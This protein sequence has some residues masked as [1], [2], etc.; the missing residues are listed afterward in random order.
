MKHIVIIFLLLY[1]S[2]LRSQVLPEWAHNYFG[3]DLLD[4][5]R[6]QSNR[7]STIDPDSICDKLIEIDRQ[8]GNNYINRF[9]NKAFSDRTKYNID[10]FTVY[11]NEWIASPSEQKYK[12]QYDMHLSFPILIENDD[13]VL[14][15]LYDNA[16]GPLPVEANYKNIL[17]NNIVTIAEADGSIGIWQFPEEYKGELARAFLYAAIVYHPTLIGGSGNNFLTE[18]SFPSI[19]KPYLNYLLEC[20]RMDPPS[21]REQ[22]RNKAIQ[23]I[24]KN[25]N[26]FIEYPELVDYI[27]QDYV[28]DNDI[29]HGDNNNSGNDNNKDSETTR[30]PLK[31]YYD[32]QDKYVWL[33]SPFI[34]D[35]AEWTIDGA[36]TME[37]RIPIDSL[38]KGRHTLIYKTSYEK[39]R[40]IIEIL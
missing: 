7:I 16:H 30:I 2:I 20:N 10:A 12:H 25:S 27:W 28:N 1:P 6:E 15:K 17:S 4:I 38:S 29:E 5:F 33:Y 37:Q 8:S 3:A 31:S 18:E 40:I 9:S 32:V 13:E 24:Q 23:Q 26:Y 21:E 19:K 14:K 34:S 35:N 39:G 22:L 36:V 11:Y